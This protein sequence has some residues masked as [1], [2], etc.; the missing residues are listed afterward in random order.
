MGDPTWILINPHLI[1]IATVTIWLFDIVMDAKKQLYR[2][3]IYTVFMM[4]Y[5]LKMEILG[6]PL[7]G[8]LGE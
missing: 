7:S 5:L 1:S 2:N 3:Y 6:S 8:P 4:I